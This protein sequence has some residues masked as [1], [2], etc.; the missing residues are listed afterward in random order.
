VI[1]AWPRRPDPAKGLLETI[2]VRDG[3]LIDAA[4]HL[5]RLADSARALYGI[6]VA[7]E[8]R[9]EIELGRLRV[10]VSARG[11]IRVEQYEETPNPASTVLEPRALAQGLGPHK[12]ADRP[13]EPHWLIVDGEDVLETA[14]ANIWIE[15]Q[16]ELI[17]PPADGRILPGITRARLLKSRGREQRI[18]L[19]ELRGAEV[20]FL[21]SSIRLV[22]P[23]GLSQPAS[24]RAIRL[25]QALRDD[26]AISMKTR[27]YIR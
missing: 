6:R 16:G 13:G 25:A 19:G 8:L 9:P 4:A 18:T 23:A 17:T 3:K 27:S 24:A 15:R 7:P 10:V 1:T 22:T 21:T 26:P 11:D 12:W 2:A 20:I 5:A 14:T